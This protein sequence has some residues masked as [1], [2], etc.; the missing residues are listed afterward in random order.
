MWHLSKEVSADESG[1][2]GAGAGAPR[3]VGIGAKRGGGIRG[4]GMV[5]PGAGWWLAIIVGLVV[6]AAPEKANRSV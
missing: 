3:G 1:G 6:V 4:G 2:A 5:G